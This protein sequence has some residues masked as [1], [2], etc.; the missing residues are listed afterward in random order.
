MNW[1]ELR[2]LPCKK[3]GALSWAIAGETNNGGQQVHRMVCGSCGYR[4]PVFVPKK[5]VEHFAAYVGK[6]VAYAPPKESAP[7]CEVCGVKGAEEHH[8]APFSIFGADAHKWPKSHL[9]PTCHRE[10]H[11]RV[12]P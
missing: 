10:W 5:V 11:L 9:C 8:W 7:D 3:C 4:P 6:S 12:T 1:R 2:D